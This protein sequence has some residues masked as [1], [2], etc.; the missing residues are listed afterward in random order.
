MNTI[1]V[2]RDV[3]QAAEKA[4]KAWI[5]LLG[6]T[7]PLTHNLKVLQDLLVGLDVDTEAFL[8]LVEY[9]P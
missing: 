9:T 7:Y 4:F 1:W 3:Q 6:E 5:A 8:E 2:L